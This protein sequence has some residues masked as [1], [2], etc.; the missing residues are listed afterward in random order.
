MG[1]GELLDSLAAGELGDHVLG[2]RSGST[3]NPSS[4]SS[5]STFAMVLVDMSQSFVEVPIAA[6][7][8]PAVGMAD[9]MPGTSRPGKRACQ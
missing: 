3:K 4:L 1:L 5:T 6:G 7:G 2:P 8:L 9:S